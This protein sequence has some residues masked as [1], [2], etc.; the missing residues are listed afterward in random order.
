MSSPFRA[1]NV[2]LFATLLVCTLLYTAACLRYDGFFSW[3]VFINFFRENAHLGIALSLLFA[4]RI[5]YRLVEVFGLN[6]G[7]PHDLQ[8]FGRSPLTR[9]CIAARSL[10]IDSDRLRARSATPVSLP[11]ASMVE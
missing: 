8:D 9:A 3:G 4:A 10:R 5:A 11:I 1:K 7:V 6:P 2:P